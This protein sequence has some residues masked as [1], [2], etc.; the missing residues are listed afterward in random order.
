MVDWLAL[1]SLAVNRYF[2]GTLDDLI[3]FCQSVAVKILLPVCGSKSHFEVH[4]LITGAISV[5]KCC[6]IS[7]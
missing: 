3:R 2:G 7:V 1:L 6:L 4:R 5:L